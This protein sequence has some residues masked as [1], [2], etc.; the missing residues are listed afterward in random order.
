MSLQEKHQLLEQVLSKISHCHITEIAKLIM[1]FITVDYC[2]EENCDL[3]LNIN[4]FCDDGDTRYHFL[5]KP[6][7]E[8]RILLYKKLEVQN[9]QRHG[10]KVLKVY[11]KY[12]HETHTSEKIEEIYGMH[13]ADTHLYLESPKCSNHEYTFVSEYTKMPYTTRTELEL[14]LRAT[15]AYMTVRK[16]QGDHVNATHEVYFMRNIYV[17]SLYDPEA[18]DHRDI[19][20][21]YKGA[22]ELFYTIF[23]SL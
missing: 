21:D 17:F 13:N 23:S 11:T 19:K 8:T 20:D 14:L 9:L 5:I 3:M 12:N 10:N 22:L 7:D 15:N 1:S 4:Y 2:S 16:R 6:I 18:D